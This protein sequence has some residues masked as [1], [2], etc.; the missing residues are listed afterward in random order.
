MTPI[1]INEAEVIIEAGQPLEMSVRL[2]TPQPAEVRAGES[3]DRRAR[4]F[5]ACRRSE[6]G[7]GE[8]TYHGDEGWHQTQ[9][10]Q[11]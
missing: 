2:H 9:A 10:G 6:L 4:R 7:A 11:S 3:L 5:P 8:R 1:P